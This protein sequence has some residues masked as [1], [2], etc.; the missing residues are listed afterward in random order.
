MARSVHYEQIERDIHREFRASRIP[1]TEYFRLSEQQL[2]V[3]VTWLQ[4]EHEAGDAVIGQRGKWRGVLRLFVVGAR[5]AHTLA[6]HYEKVTFLVMTGAACATA[7]LLSGEHWPQL[8]ILI[9]GLV[10]LVLL[11][12]LILMAFKWLVRGAR[13]H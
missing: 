12:A 8:A 11:A 5:L 2:R 4:R 3:I 10:A 13:G 6:C 9:A 7:L 1:Q